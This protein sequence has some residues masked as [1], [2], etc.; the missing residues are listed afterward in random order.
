MDI[1]KLGK[2][3][4]IAFTPVELSAMEADL[5]RIIALLEPLRELELPEP[6]ED[7]RAFSLP[8]LPE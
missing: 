2:L 1:A 7:G 3:S 6:E 8:E 5:T 4:K